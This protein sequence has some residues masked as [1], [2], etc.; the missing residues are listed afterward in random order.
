MANVKDLLNK[1]SNGG[2]KFEYDNE[3]ERDYIKLGELDMSKTYPIEAL[4]INTKGK[5]GDQ[6]VIISGDYIVNLPQHLT[7][8][9]EDMR[10]DEEMVEAINQRLFDFEIYEFESKKYN[11]KSH[12]INLVPSENVQQEA[13]SE[14]K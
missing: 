9:I 14:K 4:F 10:K 5:F 1:Y 7:E 2:A 11:R 13:Q 12:G 6:G 8:M 3:K